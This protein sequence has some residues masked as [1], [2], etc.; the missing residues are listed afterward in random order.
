MVIKEEPDKV[1]PAQRKQMIEEIVKPYLQSSSPD[2]WRSALAAAMV[3]AT[4]P[5]NK[6]RIDK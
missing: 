5:L 1:D 2:D 6:Y 3:A 4:I